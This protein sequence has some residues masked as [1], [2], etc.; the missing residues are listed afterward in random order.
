M[1]YFQK[2][3]LMRTTEEDSPD[4]DKTNI[5]PDCFGDGMIL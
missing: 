2:R 1:I 4:G 5:R 3:L